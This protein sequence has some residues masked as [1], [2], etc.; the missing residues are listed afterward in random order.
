[1]ASRNSQAKPPINSHPAFPA[2]VA[3]WFAVLLGIGSLIVPAALFERLFAIGGVAEILPAAQPPL[4]I[5]ARLI[6]A[7]TGSVIGGATGLLLARLAAPAQVAPVARNVQKV[8]SPKEKRPISAL[9]EL[10]S[11]SLDQPV[12]A[13]NFIELA[14]YER[15]ALITPDQSEPGNPAVQA[16]SAVDPA[17]HADNRQADNSTEEAGSQTA[18]EELSRTSNAFAQVPLDVPEPA[19]P[20]A[21]PGL[22]AEQLISRP[23]DELGIVQLVER[24]ALSLQQR[25]APARRQPDHEQPQPASQVRPPTPLAAPRAAPPRTLPDALRPVEFG[26]DSSDSVDDDDE[27]S[28]LLTLK[29]VPAQP[30]RSVQLPGADDTRQA[31]TA[32]TF[33]SAD[34]ASSIRK[35]DAPTSSSAAD[36]TSAGRA[37]AADTERTLRD[38]L[39]QLQKMTGTG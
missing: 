1:M 31:D 21:H 5:A 4:G 15:S 17:C 19:T 23:L 11:P 26:F 33:P 32:G 30:R 25:A 8:D 39:A 3:L 16:P 20:N 12:E 24:F 37:S 7:I 28:S 2:I 6:I 29:K 27:F 34:G 9:E 35:F 18:E 13:E 22:T 14:P 38:A 10:G 36:A